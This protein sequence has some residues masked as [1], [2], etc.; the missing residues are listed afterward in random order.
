VGNQDNKYQFQLSD[1]IEKLS[2]ELRTPLGA[3]LGYSELLEKSENL[4]TN[5]KEHLK[6]ISSSG[7]QLLDLINDIIEIS[8]IES[9]HVDIEENKVHT[10]ELVAE[11][12]DKFK[13]QARYKE[14]DFTIDCKPAVENS[15]ITDG[16]K[17]KSILF[18]LISNAV[19][20]T[21]QGHIQVELN[22]VDRSNQK[23]L[24]IRV[25]DT[26]VGI[27]EDDFAHIFDPFWQGKSREKSGTGLGLTTCKKLVEILGGTISLQ[28]EFGNGTSVDVQIP[29]KTKAAK[30]KSFR[31][32][33]GGILK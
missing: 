15:F 23:I 27:H 32:V 25:I 4:D 9:G 17:L 11:L 24:D 12:M 14:I 33:A 22:M 13:A 20:F 18:S 30:A 31:A 19:K 21:E 7:S 10:K 2:H 16:R 6:K 3:I 8:N 1:I 5:E 26:G 28:S 29:V